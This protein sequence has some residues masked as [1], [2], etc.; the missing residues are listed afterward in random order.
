MNAIKWDKNNFS[1][2]LLGQGSSDL[3]PGEY[4]PVHGARIIG[5]G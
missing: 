4:S 1:V 5:G 2:D 3:C